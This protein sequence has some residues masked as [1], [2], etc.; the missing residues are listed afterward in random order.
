MQPNY[1]PDD[2][3]FASYLDNTDAKAT[4]ANLSCNLF[5]KVW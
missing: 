3:D 2:I 5:R 4:H 1:V